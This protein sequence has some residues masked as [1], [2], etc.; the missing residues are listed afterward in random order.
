METAGFSNLS[1]IVTRLESVRSQEFTV[2]SKLLFGDASALP[3]GLTRM[4]ILLSK[5]S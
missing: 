1:V 2:F 5:V 3:S 4:D